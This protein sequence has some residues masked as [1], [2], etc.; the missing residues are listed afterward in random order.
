MHPRIRQSTAHPRFRT[1]S[2]FVIAVALAASAPCAALAQQA[3]S[4]SGRVTD[5][6]TGQPLGG[7]HMSLPGSLTGA[8]SRSDGSYRLSV[9]PGRHALLIS[10]VGY[11]P[12]R[13]T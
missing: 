8:V 4:V 6:E 2:S 9:T 10:Y 3:T 13:D 1:F 12:R 11:A 5:R 7:A